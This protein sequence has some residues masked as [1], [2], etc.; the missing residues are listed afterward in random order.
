[1]L[2]EP[3]G[4]LKELQKLSWSWYFKDKGKKKYLDA[5]DCIRLNLEEHRNTKGPFELNNKMANIEK[6][7]LIFGLKK[8]ELVKSKGNSRVRCSQHFKGEFS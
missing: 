3:K 8:Y 5:F 2:P 4:K 7:E 6:K 1:M